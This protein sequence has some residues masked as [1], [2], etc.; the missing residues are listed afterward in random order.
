M[1][2]PADYVKKDRFEREKKSRAEVKRVQNARNNRYG[3]NRSCGSSQKLQKIFK[4]SYKYMKWPV[5]TDQIKI[6]SP[7]TAILNNVLKNN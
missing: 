2:V 4:K 5:H 1:V 6:M 7:K 3:Q